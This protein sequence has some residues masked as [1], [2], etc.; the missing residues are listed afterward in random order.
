[1][2]NFDNETNRKKAVNYTKLKGKGSLNNTKKRRVHHIAFDVGGNM[3]FG[4]Q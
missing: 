2:L 3:T 4:V 1:M